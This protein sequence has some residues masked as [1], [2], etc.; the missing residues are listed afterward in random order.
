MIEIHKNNDLSYN[1]T[2]VVFLGKEFSAPIDIVI[3]M[4]W[5]YIF[6][7]LKKEKND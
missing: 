4:A 1:P 5:Q 6:N 3:L 7:L 2:S